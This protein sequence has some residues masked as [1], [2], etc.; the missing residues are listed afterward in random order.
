M[1]KDRPHQPFQRFA[2]QVPG[3]EV[4]IEVQKTR[5]EVIKLASGNLRAG[6]IWP[7][8]PFAETFLTMAPVTSLEWQREK[9]AIEDRASTPVVPSPV[10]T[11]TDDEYSPTLLGDPSPAASPDKDESPFSLSETEGAPNDAAP[12]STGDATLG[13]ADAPAA[14]QAL[15]TVMQDHRSVSPRPRATS[16]ADGVNTFGLD[17]EDPSLKSVQERIQLFGSKTRAAS[18][19]LQHAVDAAVESAAPEPL[20]SGKTVTLAPEATSEPASSS[21]DQIPRPPFITGHITNFTIHS[22]RDARSRS[23]TPGTH[24]RLL[25]MTTELEQERQE[26]L[27]AVAARLAMNDELEKTRRQ[28]MDLE[29]KF[30]ALQQQMASILNAQLEKP[31]G[32]DTGGASTSGNGTSSVQAPEDAT[33]AAGEST[34][35]ATKDEVWSRRTDESFH[36]CDSGVDPAVGFHMVTGEEE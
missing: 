36:E 26:R 14:F 34:P 28:Q 16:A 10:K 20:T 27:E 2:N 7:D 11:I 25:E 22:P 30:L 13:M 5:V 18:P 17:A 35:T 19:R 33:A 8:V 9:R 3:N 24:R 31:P 21:T 23:V 29:E 6:I 15:K 12:Q 32:S 1:K 4:M